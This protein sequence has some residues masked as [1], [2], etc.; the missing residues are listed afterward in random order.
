MNI[1]RIHSKKRETRP[2]DKKAAIPVALPPLRPKRK[3]PVKNHT[4][5]DDTPDHDAEFSGMEGDSGGNSGHNIN[6]GRKSQAQARTDMTFK[7]E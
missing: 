3:K 2:I 6:R 7:T 5:L 4:M 1:D